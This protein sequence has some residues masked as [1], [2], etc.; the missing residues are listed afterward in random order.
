LYYYSRQQKDFITN[1]NIHNVTFNK[2]L[3]NNT[4]Y[5]GKYTFSIDLELTARAS[6]ISILNLALKLKKDRIKF[7]KNKPI[8]S[9]TRIM[10]LTSIKNSK[11][12]KLFYGIKS[13][14]D[15]L[16]KKKGL[17]STREILI[18]YINNDKP[19]HGYTCKYV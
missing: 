13:C 10:S 4:Y 3:I 9:E 19:Y 11:D 7:N 8:I 1:L 5:L 18:K 12:V 17:P 15:Y 16:N 6:N 14:I 2:H